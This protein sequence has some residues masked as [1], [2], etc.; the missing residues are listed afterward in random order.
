M[1][2]LFLQLGH[3]D[4]DCVTELSVF[5]NKSRENISAL[6]SKVINIRQ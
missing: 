6:I 1:V 4:E 3:L 2:R 5:H